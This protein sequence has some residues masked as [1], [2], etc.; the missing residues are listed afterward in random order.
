MKKL[1]IVLLSFFFACNYND[2]IEES[3][4][5]CKHNQLTCKFVFS[6]DTCVNDY[7]FA[8]YIP[9]EKVKQN[10]TVVTGK[11]VRYHDD[12]SNAVIFSRE[13]ILDLCLSS[14]CV[15]TERND[16]IFGN[17]V[18]YYFPE[19]HIGFYRELNSG[20]YVYSWIVLNGK[21]WY[22]NWCVDGLSVTSDIETVL[23]NLDEYLCDSLPSLDTGENDSVYI[24]VWDLIRSFYKYQMYGIKKDDFIIYQNEEDL[25]FIRRG[26]NL[27]KVV[28]NNNIIEDDKSLEYLKNIFMDDLKK[29]FVM[30]DIHI[31]NE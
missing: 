1:L 10:L 9:V 25:F 13:Y 15:S 8:K 24:K 21:L 11:Y 2:H 19:T 4:N 17:I 27:S 3:E 29:V 5:G 7:V 31:S 20:F 28:F 12:N 6:G 23:C 18:E 22:S 30:E 14:D 26:N 16:S